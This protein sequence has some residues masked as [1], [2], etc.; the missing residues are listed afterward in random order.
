MA[1]EMGNTKAANNA[2]PPAQPSTMS[3]A[4]IS[5]AA[6]KSLTNPSGH[7][8]SGHRRGWP[9]RENLQLGL[10]RLGAAV[11]DSKVISSEIA[12]ASYLWLWPL[13]LGFG[14]AN[15]PS[16]LSSLILYS[17]LARATSLAVLHK[18][19]DRAI[20]WAVQSV[21]MVDGASIHRQGNFE[22]R[23]LCCETE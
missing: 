9:C 5:S 11:S 21:S 14:T 10:C 7:H 15:L 23:A 12:V 1:L 3:A 2:L 17:L 19:V 8:R 13:T 22:Q 16:P 4:M 6:N 18:R 20:I